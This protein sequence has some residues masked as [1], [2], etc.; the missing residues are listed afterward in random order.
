MDLKVWLTMVGGKVEYC[1]DGMQALCPAAPAAESTAEATSAG[2]RDDFDSASLDEGCSWIREDPA[3]GSLAERP[4]WLRLSTG[5][6]S[7]LRAGGDAPLLVHPAPDGDF[8]ILTRLDF[9]PNAHF[10]V[11]QLL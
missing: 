7:L 5:N 2:F 10:Q 11:A 6:F 1:A 9:A 4:G 8:E 3:V